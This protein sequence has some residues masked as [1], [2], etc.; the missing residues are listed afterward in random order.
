MK[1]FI[2]FST[3][4]ILLFSCTKDRIED[5]DNPIGPNNPITEGYLFINE[6]VARGSQQTNEFGTTEDWMEIFNPSFS[7]VV[8][9]AGKWFVSDAGPSNPEKYAL[10]QVTI[11]ARGFL[12]IWCDGLNLVETQIHASF[13]LSAAGEHLV[14]YYKASPSADGVIVDEYEYGEQISG[15]SEGRYPDG[16]ETWTFFNSP[17]LGASNN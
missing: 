10:P 17:T 4:L 8:L 1:Y 12:V 7:D 11:P 2:L 16:G 6:F 9:E 14:I 13:S 5:S 15:K 3:T